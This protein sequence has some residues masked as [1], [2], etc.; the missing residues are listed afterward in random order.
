MAYGAWYGRTGGSSSPRRPAAPS[1]RSA[2]PPRLLI[3]LALAPAPA[4][5]LTLGPALVLALGHAPAL[6][7]GRH[8]AVTLVA[9]GPESDGQTERM[10]ALV[11]HYLRTYCTYLQDDWAPSFCVSAEFGLNNHASDA[12]H[13]TPFFANLGQHPRTGIEP[14]VPSSGLPLNARAAAETSR[15]DEFAADLDHL[16]AFCK[17]Q[18]EYARARYESAADA[19]R[20]HAPA[21]KPGDV[22]WLDTRNIKTRR[23]SKK[24][25]HRFAGPLHVAQK[26]SSHAYRIKLPE[27]WQVH[28]TFQT[29]VGT[30]PQLG[31][32]LSPSFSFADRLVSYFEYH[33]RTTSLTEIAYPAARSY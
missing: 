29:S 21:Y 28:D 6:A 11:E 18:I 31:H 10:N 23:S 32:P 17:T 24:L 19:H 9:F 13:V 30:S 25:D 1:L 33:V 16:S 15:V 14:S 20:Q 12:T 2:S 3:A 8:V 26:I 7:L 5:A 27:G 4:L 22:V